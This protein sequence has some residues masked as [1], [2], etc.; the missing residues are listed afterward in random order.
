MINEGGQREAKRKYVHAGE[1][2]WNK[3]A[4]KID[5]INEVKLDTITKLLDNDNDTFLDLIIIFDFFNQSKKILEN[6]EIKAYLYIK[7]YMFSI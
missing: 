1:L 6:Q 3:T 7:E 4:N 2:K 5:Q